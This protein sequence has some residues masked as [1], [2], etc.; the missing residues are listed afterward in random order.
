[1]LVAE[2]PSSDEFLTEPKLDGF[3]MSI[4]VD[5]GR[6]RLVSRHG[7]V[8]SHNFPTICDAALR[9]PLRAALLDG[10][11]TVLLPSGLTSFQA[12]QNR[13]SLPPSAA[14]VFHAFEILHLDGEDVGRR[15]LEER[16]AMLEQLLEPEAE[17]GVLRYLPHIIG[18]G[19]RVLKSACA[20][21]MEGVVSKRRSAPHVA[22]RSRAWLKCKCLRSEPF[23][24]GGFTAAGDSLGSLLV[25]QYD[26]VGALHYA[27]AVGTGKGFTRA[28]LR[29]LRAQLEPYETTLSPFLDFSSAAVRSPWGKRQAAP[30]HWVQPVVVVDIGFLE[31]TDTGQLRHASFQRFRPDLNPRT[32]IDTRRP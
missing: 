3:R 22:G 20:L 11:L 13:S 17:R 24:I 5:A 6:A 2:P 23:V 12:L 31:R 16:K 30:T 14:L 10:E 9:L 26:A 25:G 8:W 18:D 1:M 21:G 15:P 28:F 32:V 27:S 29:E 4:T 7:K 19:P